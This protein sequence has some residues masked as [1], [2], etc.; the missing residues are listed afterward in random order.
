MTGT[1]DAETRLLGLFE[2][3]M[4]D[5]PEIGV[6]SFSKHAGLDLLAL[7]P[8]EWW[9]AFRAHYT[10]DGAVDENRIGGDL[11]T[12]GPIAARVVELQLKARVAA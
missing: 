4:R 2:D 6:L 1:K 7:P 8:A 11:A 9:S 5:P 10:A 3:L 12:W